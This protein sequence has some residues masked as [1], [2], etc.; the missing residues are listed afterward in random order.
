MSDVHEILSV[1]GKSERVYVPSDDTFLMID[2]LNTLQLRGKQVLDVGTGSGILGLMCAKMGARVTLTDIEDLT[3]EK[4]KTTARSLNL[5]IEALRSD[6][7]S[8]LE[9]K[10]DVVVFNPP[11]LPSGEI[12]DAAVDG[13]NEGRRLIDRFLTEL[14]RHLKEDGYALLLVSSV[15]D[16][17]AIMDSHPELTFT[18]VTS[19]SIF[20]EELLVLLCKSRNRS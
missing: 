18:I 1:I 16:P 14:P 5:T 12:K 15:N 7:F 13:G 20:F 11:Y 8:N 4:V 17:R 2:A 19:R 6:I 10:F 9:G 3:L